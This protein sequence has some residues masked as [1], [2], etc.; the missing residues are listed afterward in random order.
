MKPR[1]PHPD[2]QL[3]NDLIAFAYLMNNPR[4]ESCLVECDS[5]SGTINPQ[6]RLDARHAGQRSRI[7][8]RCAPGD[9]PPLTAPK[10]A[11]SLRRGRTG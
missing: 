11:M 1:K 4:A 6:L 2:R 7:A 10:P 5:R 9:D 8:R 3:R